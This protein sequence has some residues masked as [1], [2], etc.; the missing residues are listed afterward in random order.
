M[1]QTELP[2]GRLAFIKKQKTNRSSLKQKQKQIQD[3]VCLGWGVR[4]SGF[5]GTVPSYTDP[6]PSSPSRPVSSLPTLPKALH[7]GSD[8][9]GHFQGAGFIRW[10]RG[11]TLRLPP[12]PI[13]LRAQ[14]QSRNLKLP[15]PSDGVLAAARSSPGRWRCGLLLAL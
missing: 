10:D 5:L 1:P 4:L 11:R 2:N 15:R 9:E 7:W 13:F 14:T 6:S 12:P 8:F 3:T